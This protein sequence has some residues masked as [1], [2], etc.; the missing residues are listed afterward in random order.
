[1]FSRETH[2]RVSVLKAFLSLKR[3]EYP[4]VTLA[5]LT[6]LLLVFTSDPGFVPDVV[7]VEW[8]EHN[9]G[10]Y[11]RLDSADLNEVL[12]HENPILALPQ[13]EDLSLDCRKEIRRDNAP[14]PPEDP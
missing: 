11:A 10:F 8:R 5:A 14:E 9:C 2:S 6:A 1:M 12:L 13:W 4:V 7:H 3:G